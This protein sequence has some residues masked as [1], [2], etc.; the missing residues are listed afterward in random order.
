MTSTEN[1]IIKIPISLPYTDQINIPKDTEGLMEKNGQFYTAI[2]KYLDKDTLYV[3][4]HENK[5]AREIFDLLTDHIN[6]ELN[7]DFPVNKNNTHLNLSL[8]ILA[9]TGFDQNY[10][11]WLNVN[12]YSCFASVFLMPAYLK[13]KLPNPTPP[14]ETN[15]V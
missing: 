8:K 10:Q 11:T 3:S 5:G 7:N 2:S 15:F 1:L 13:V 14:P 9:I 4:Y 6:G 12:N